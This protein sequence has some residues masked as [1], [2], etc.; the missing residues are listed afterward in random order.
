MTIDTITYG[1]EMLKALFP[2]TETHTI[3]VTAAEREAIAD[4]L[5]FM[6]AN[7]ADEPTTGLQ[8]IPRHAVFACSK[9][10]AEAMESALIKAKVW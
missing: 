5:R 4:A 3:T 10:E 8:Y 2:P 1:P 7:L 9:S 6:V